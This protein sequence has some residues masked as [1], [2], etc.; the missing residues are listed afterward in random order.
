MHERFEFYG[1]PDIQRE[2]D[3]GREYTDISQVPPNKRDMKRYIFQL[4]KKMKDIQKSIAKG[5][6]AGA[7]AL[8]DEFLKI[9]AALR[10]ASQQL[11]MLPEGLDEAFDPKEG[12]G[13]WYRMKTRGGEGYFY[14][15]GTFKNDNAKGYQVDVQHGSR[16]RK[17][18][19]SSI[20]HRTLG[21]EW[22]RI[23]EKDVPAPVMAKFR[24]VMEG[25]DW[26][27]SIARAR[28]RLEAREPKPK[29][30]KGDRV[31]ETGYN[32]TGEI[33]SV[34]N[35]DDHVG[36]RRYHFM[37]DDGKRTKRWVFEKNLVKIK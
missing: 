11:R 22:K 5:Q 28:A 31:K 10:Q 20:F 18:K 13:E 23:Q 2:L 16:P 27:G 12:A 35:Y 25:F 37:F 34:G 19:S 4:K 3:E 8:R 17:A 15:T 36:S 14:R 29:F 32:A 30:K 33:W 9:Q 7:A 1:A 6:Q 24:P 26:Q 21:A